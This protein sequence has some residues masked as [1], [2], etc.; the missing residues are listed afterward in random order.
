MELGAFHGEPRKH[1]PPYKGTEAMR[2]SSRVGTLA[3]VG[4]Q[5]KA[6][7]R[8][9]EIRLKSH[10]LLPTE[11]WALLEDC[12]FLFTKGPSAHQRM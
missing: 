4:P 3:S 5:A 7:R 2:N 6:P 10:L 9:A 12:I 8:G 11:T 1:E